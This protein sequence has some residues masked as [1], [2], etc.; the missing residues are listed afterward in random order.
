MGGVEHAKLMAWEDMRSTEDHAENALER[1]G[2]AAPL[3]GA[4]GWIDSLA[5]LVAADC[6]DSQDFGALV[7]DLFA[8]LGFG[9]RRVPTGPGPEGEALIATRPTGRPA[10]SIHFRLD[11]TPSEAGWSRPSRRLTRQ[12][13]RLY[14]QGTAGV[15][16]AVAAVWAA[17]RAS[18]AVGLELGF[19]P[20]LVFSGSDAGLVRLAARGEVNGHVLSLNGAAAPRLWAGC[21]GSVELEVRLRGEGAPAEMARSVLDHLA[22]LQQAVAQRPGLPGQQG[23]GQPG[24]P[25]PDLS[26]AV[27]EPDPEGGCRLRLNRR[28]AAE[29]S[30]AAVVQ[31]LEAAVVAACRATPG[32]SVETR[33]AQ[34]LPPVVDPDC[35][36]HGPRWRQALGWG[37]GFPC[38]GFERQASSAASAFGLVQ[39]AGIQE[40]LMGGLIRPGLRG[41][42]ADE[43]T[44]VEDVEALART[45]LAYLSD[46]PDIPDY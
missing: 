39:Q 37:F 41:P 11:S 3:L 14:G 27:A 1:L 5:R 32:L 28:Y 10:C 16:G 30:Y 34:H 15:K 8:P 9:L 35:G 6:I 45:I 38:G 29:E 42:G 20:V 2:M 17:L 46:A 40:I 33:L 19:D 13:H 31:E 25:R 43:C 24:G 36:P 23:P 26:M 22:G 12:G 7:R 21:L 4:T 18:D 44:T